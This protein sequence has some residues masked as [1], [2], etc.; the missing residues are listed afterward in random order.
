MHTPKLNFKNASRRDTR[1]FG[2][3]PDSPLRD[4]VS[5][6]DDYGSEKVITI[7]SD[8]EEEERALGININHLKNEIRNIENERDNEIDE[9]EKKIQKSRDNAEIRII[10]IRKKLKNYY[11]KQGSLKLKRVLKEKE[12]EL[13][14]KFAEKLPKY[15]D[16]IIQTERIE[17]EVGTVKCGCCEE[18]IDINIGHCTN[19]YCANG[20]CG[21][22]HERVCKC[23]KD[24]YL[25]MTPEEL[26]EEAETLPDRATYLKKHF[27]DL[28][29]EKESKKSSNFKL[30]DVE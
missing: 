4:Y 8:S 6:A 22:C 23:L 21:G 17:Q 3:A 29:K 16:A 25:D 28:A 2:Y 20:K 24:V 18:D 10:Q 27:R 7:Y 5:G 12:K 13:K 11:K 26:R 30:N 1:F 14:K 19:V 9:W 15:K